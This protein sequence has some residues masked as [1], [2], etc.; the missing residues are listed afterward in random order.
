[1][2]A[3]KG[4]GREDAA[5]RPDEGGGHAAGFGKE[6]GDHGE[7]VHGEI[8]RPNRE[9]DVIAPVERLADVVAVMDQHGDD[10]DEPAEKHG[11]R[12]FFI[13]LLVEHGGSQFVG[14]EI[15]PLIKF[16]YWL[17]MTIW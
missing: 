8:Q 10:H 14:H 17:L 1:M 7:D 6:D 2:Q 12:G 11:M 4:R 13:Q 5:D 15:S 9:R 16:T 3:Q